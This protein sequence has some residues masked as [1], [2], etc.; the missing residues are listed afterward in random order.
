MEPVIQKIADALVD[1]Y[2]NERIAEF[3]ANMVEEKKKFS[4]ANMAETFLCV[5][6]TI[7]A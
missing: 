3:E 5:Y 6:K 2:E 1:F 4:W 7:K